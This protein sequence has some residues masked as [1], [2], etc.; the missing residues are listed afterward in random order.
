MAKIPELNESTIK[1]TLRPGNRIIV[2]W[3]KALD[4]V[5]NP[6][7]YVFGVQCGLFCSPDFHGTEYTFNGLEPGKEY[8]IWVVCYTAKNNERVCENSE[9]I[10]VKTLADEVLPVLNNSTVKITNLESDSFTVSWEK[11][12]DGVPN[13]QDYVFAAQCERICSPRLN[14]THYTFSDLEP[15]KEYRLAVVCFTAK[16]GE[17]VCQMP[18]TII[19]KTLKEEAS[20]EPAEPQAKPND[21]QR[22]KQINDGLASIQ[23]SPAFLINDTLYND[24]KLYPQAIENRLE[25]A[26]YLLSITPTEE[27]E[28]EIYVRGTEFESIYPGAILIVDS[29]L[30]SGSPHTLG[31]IE[32]GKINLYGD[33]LAQDSTKQSDVYPSNEGTHTAITNI[34]RLLLK[35]PKYKPPGTIHPRTTIYSSQQQMMLDFRVDSSFAGINLNVSAKTDSSEQSFIQATTLDQEYFTVKM[36]DSWK[37]DPSSLFAP[38]VTWDRLREILRGNAIAIVTSVTYG[39]TFSYLKEFSSKKFTYTG[40]QTIKG[41]GQEAEAGQNMAESREFTNEDIFNLGGTSLPIAVL[42]SKKTQADLEKAMADNMEFS[43]SNQGVITRYTLHLITGPYPGTT[44]KPKYNLK[45]NTIRYMRCP[46][47]VK[48]HL[49]VHDVTFGGVGGGQARVHM[50]A[51]IFQVRNGEPVTILKIQRMLPTKTRDP[52]FWTTRVNKDVTFGDLE[53]GNYIKPKPRVWVQANMGYS[54]GLKEYKDKDEKY[55]DI[56]TGAIDITLSGSVYGQVSIA[57]ID[58]K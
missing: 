24:K 36:D 40:S 46:R 51:E 45:T 37:Q 25:D 18:E 34:M 9:P 14:K 21:A 31:S 50:D 19:V 42:R 1:A 54:A 56:S 38:E 48:A 26:A 3:E 57:S 43:E 20:T 27:K 29:A 35:N 44:L 55:A 17:W 16:D 41:Y 7:D 8:K 23:Y 53:P 58:P 11:A 52:W 39:R 13:P 30:T 5:P 28:K 10:R 22:R 2:S 6:Q 15:D 32:R 33:F 4:G 47:N 12:L 49:D